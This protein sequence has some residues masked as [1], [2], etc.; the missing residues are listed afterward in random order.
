MTDNQEYIRIHPLDLCPLLMAQ[1]EAG[2]LVQKMDTPL[3][4]P[5]EGGVMRYTKFLVIDGKRYLPTVTATRA[6]S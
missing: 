4:I 1:A 2:V 3:D 6:Q 5:V